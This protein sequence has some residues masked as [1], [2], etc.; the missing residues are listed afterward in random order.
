LRC[1]IPRPPLADRVER[2]SSIDTAG[3]DCDMRRVPACGIASHLPGG[4]LHLRHMRA[5]I[6]QAL[7]LADRVERRAT[8]CADKNGGSLLGMK[9]SGLDDRE[10]PPDSRPPRA[11]FL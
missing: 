10:I 3:T 5:A 8:R 9:R 7:E 2:R 4:W 11:F 1:F 6:D